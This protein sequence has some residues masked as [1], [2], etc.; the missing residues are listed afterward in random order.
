MNKIIALDY[1]H[2]Q[3]LIKEEIDKN[4]NNCSLN[5]LDVELI[6]NMDMLFWGLPFDGDI[7]QWNTSNVKSMNAMF[8]CSPFNRDISKWD[9]SQVENMSNMF[10]NSKFN[11]DISQWNTSNVKKMSSM[12]RNSSFMQDISQWNVEKVQSMDAMF[13][14]SKLMKESKKW[15]KADLS[16]LSQEMKNPSQNFLPYWNLRTQAERIETI[17]A[18]KSSDEMMLINQL[19]DINEVTDEEVKKVKKKI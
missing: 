9:V 13:S 7:S 15:I 10:Q 14:D 19:I 1:F 5:H 8:F 3:T 12:F 16:Q 6:D 4:G 11:Q 18:K 17:L 2:L